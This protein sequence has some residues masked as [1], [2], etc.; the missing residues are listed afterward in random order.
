MKIQIYKFVSSRSCRD[1]MPLEDI[2]DSILYLAC[3]YL[4]TDTFITTVTVTCP[5]YYSVGIK[6]GLIITC[7]RLTQL[8]FFHTFSLS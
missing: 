6:K 1:S 4:N 5:K 3:N 7:A 2:I 8:F